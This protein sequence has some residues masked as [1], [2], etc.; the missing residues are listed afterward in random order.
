MT[1]VIRIM[2]ENNPLEMLRTLAFRGA[3]TLHMLQPG[4]VALVASGQ[5]K[6]GRMGG[7]AG[8]ESMSISEFEQKNKTKKKGRK[9]R[10]MSFMPTEELRLTEKSF[11]SGE[12]IG[13]FSMPK[14]IV[15]VTDLSS[16]ILIITTDLLANFSEEALKCIEQL[17]KNENSSDSKTANEVP[18]EKL[19]RVCREFFRMCD[20]DNSGEISPMEFTMVMRKQ[21]KKFGPQFKDWFNRPLVIFEQIDG[22]WGEKKQLSFLYC[23]AA[24]L[25]FSYVFFF[26]PRVYVWVRRWQWYNRRG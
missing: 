10:R 21:A 18:A 11:M 1:E 8:R 6:L 15:T 9:S 14:E 22:K 12:T 25:I 24:F 2:H 19:D 4:E 3:N 7:G 20:E 16:E 17:S 26:P 5:F 13:P 23:R